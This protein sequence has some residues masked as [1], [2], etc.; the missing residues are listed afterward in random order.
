MSS[1]S[2][3]EG[4]YDALAGDYDD[5]ILRCV[6]RYHEMLSAI[7]RYVPGGLAPRRILELGSGSGHLTRLVL[8]AFPPAG[9]SP[10]KPV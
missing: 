5:A 3:S 8:K 9:V 10:P 1:A 6:P 7:I 4:F 2:G